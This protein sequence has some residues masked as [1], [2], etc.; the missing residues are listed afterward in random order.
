MIETLAPM[1]AQAEL[2]AILSD[3][4]RAGAAP[5]RAAARIRK[6]LDCL[7]LAAESPPPSSTK[8]LYVDVPPVTEELATQL[9]V[10]HLGLAAAYYESAG[11]GLE[12]VLARARAA[13]TAS[14]SLSLAADRAWIREL[15]RAYKEIETDTDEGED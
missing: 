6:A 1:K 15:D 4:A 7:I 13:G 12:I 8:N 2:D 10:H 11:V 5:R 9:V 3:M 14:P